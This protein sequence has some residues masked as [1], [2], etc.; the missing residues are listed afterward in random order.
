M[1]KDFSARAAGMGLLAAFV[2]YASS[3]AIVLAGL[4]AM[5]ATDTQAAT[6]LLFATLGMGICGAWL[7]FTTR[8]PAAVAWST[9]GAAFLASTA[10]LPG[11]FAE[12]TGAFI[13]CAMMI[14]GTGFVPLLGRLVAAIPKP[15]ASALLAG[16]LLKLC[17]APALALGTIPLMVLPVIAAWLI[18]LTINKLLAMP[19]AV[20]A[21][22][23]VLALVTESPPGAV[24]GLL[25]DIEPQAPL[26]TLQSLVSVSIPLYLVTMAGQNIPGF[27]LLE[28]NQYPVQRQKLLQTTGWVS[29]LIAPF[30]AI[31]VNMS[32]IT[33]AMMCGEDAGTDPQGR[34]W[35]AL[36]CGMAYVLLAFFS[37]AIIN[38]AALAPAGLI[39]AV[40][41]LALIPALVASVN[42]AFSE[43]L[44]LEAPAL[45]FLIT[46]SG[47]TLMGISGAFWGVVTGVII[48]QFKRYRDQP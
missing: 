4:T 26:F 17:F 19:L 2:G 28:L 1:L 14:I 45:T 18:G 37:S 10:V 44:Q 34:Y 22:A 29:A 15:V 40:A 5:G 23:L 24:A 41:G 43:S 30:G 33:A 48:W 6:G 32:A 12:A 47:M 39:T 21:F 3:F 11:G 16:V 13:C 7:A 38:I 31:P 46:A 8:T 36:I 25:P 20:I 9:P 42:A 27:T 35:A